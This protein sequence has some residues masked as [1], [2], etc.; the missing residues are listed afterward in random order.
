LELTRFG[1]E[2][3]VTGHQELGDRQ[4]YFEFF[5]VAQFLEVVL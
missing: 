3:S 4:S 5:M 2:P 1:L